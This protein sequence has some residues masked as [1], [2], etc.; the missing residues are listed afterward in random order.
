MQ[1]LIVIAGDNRQIVKQ[2]LDSMTARFFTT[3]LG[4]DSLLEYLKQTE[5]DAVV[6][7]RE[8]F[9][10]VT[11][12]E[13]APDAKPIPAVVLMAAGENSV[14]DGPDGVLDVRTV[15]AGNKGQLIAAIAAA[16]KAK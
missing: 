2:Q 9:K 7:D 12:R 4:G 11:G 13:L 10:T 1:H 3:E 15:G 6:M 8:T 14:H 16:T 5:A